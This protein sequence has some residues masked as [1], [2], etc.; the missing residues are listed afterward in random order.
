MFQLLNEIGD[1]GNVRGTLASV[2]SSVGASPVVA[3]AERSEMFAA[4]GTR[5]RELDEVGG[6]AGVL[7]DSGIGSVSDARWEVEPQV[8][9]SDSEVEVAGFSAAA[10]ESEIFSGLE[11]GVGEREC[12]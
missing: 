1:A 7:V 11:G 2:T 10:C 8:V 3:D 6:K 4:S 5:V 12:A 9:P